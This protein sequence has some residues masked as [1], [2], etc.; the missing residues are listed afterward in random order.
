MENQE[1]TQ[2]KAKTMIDFSGILLTLLTGA[3]VTLDKVTGLLQVF[4]M[5]TTLLLMACIAGG[6]SIIFKIPISKTKNNPEKTMERSSQVF[7]IGL[8]FAT[9][10]ISTLFAK[11]I[12]S[13]SICAIGS[14]FFILFTL[15]ITAK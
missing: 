12:I 3:L 11:S 4:Y 14:A 1:A 13:A 15:N 9:A 5:A 6:F 8:I 7:I 2:N 10:T